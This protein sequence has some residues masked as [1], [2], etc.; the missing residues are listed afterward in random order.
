VTANVRCTGNP[1]VQY[2]SVSGSKA[3][4]ANGGPCG[5]KGERFPATF[6]QMAPE[7]ASGEFR[8]K[9]TAK[10]CPRC[11]GRVELIEADP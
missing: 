10:P 4:F 6:I 1:D 8:R 7:T 2:I 9:T 11:G 3:T 5:W